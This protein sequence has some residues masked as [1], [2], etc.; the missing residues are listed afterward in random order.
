MN[1]KRGQIALFVIIGV[2]LVTAVVLVV[3]FR[4]SI[5]GVAL[6]PEEAQR[7]VVSQVQPVRD[8]TDGC[9]LLSARKTLNT[10]GRQGGYVIPRS[11]H[12]DIP[13]LMRDAPVM[14]Y[15]LFYD[16]DTGYLN[17][18]P[19]VNEMKDELIIYLENNIDFKR[20]IDEYSP[21]ENVVDI[22]EI[23]ILPEVDKENFEVGERSGQIVIPYNY[24]VEI[25]KRNSSA[26]VEDY[27]LVVPINLARIRETAARIINKI[28]AGENYM[29]V[30]EEESEIEWEQAKENPG[31]ER[32]LMRA[33][34][35]SNPFTDLVDVV[36]N[37]KNLLF[38][39]EYQ[40]PAL[41]VPYNFYFL[42]GLPA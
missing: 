1:N 26:L 16:A 11:N 33:E 35:Y 37:E 9:M 22:K 8:F 27:E 3:V 32:L 21:F 6:T 18:L 29:E 34:A 28:S 10:M 12:Y 2:L 23:A 17:E 20:C 19:S 38:S 7:L 15:A 24:P 4:D 40:N 30:I 42:I 25:S 41:D 31:A 5:L 39:I 13:D 36:Y 14:N